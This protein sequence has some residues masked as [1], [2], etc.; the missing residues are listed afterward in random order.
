ME[1]SS[2]GDP[3][4]ERVGRF[5]VLVLSAWCGLVSGLL[6]VGTI[7]VRKRTFDPN[8]LYEMSRHFVWLIPLT[9]LCLFLALGVV[10]KLLALGLA[11]PSE[12]A[13]ASPALLVDDCSRPSWLACRGSTVW[14][15]LS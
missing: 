1:G 7:V 2:V 13:G 5:P 6:E 4:P 3:A 9:N 11:S 12:L 15:G 8:H 14:P 10:L